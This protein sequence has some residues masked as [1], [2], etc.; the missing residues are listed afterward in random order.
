M[1]FKPAVWYPIAV[2]LSLL[3]LI[4]VGFAAAE[5]VHATIHAALA[6]GFGLWAQH[7]RPR[8]VRESDPEAMLERPR[9]PLQSQ[10]DVLEND[11]SMLRQELAETQERLDFAER[12]L[13]QAREARRPDAE[14]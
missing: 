13:T 7:L 12:L 9:E 3:N 10:V 1:T 6:V 8:R 11:M 4:A 5:P 14:R 2:G